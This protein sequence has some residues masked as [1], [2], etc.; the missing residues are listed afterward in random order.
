MSEVHRV[1]KNRNYTV[2]SNYHLRD[3][4]LSL[5]AKGLL[6]LILSLPDNWKFSVRGLADINKEGVGCIGA[7][8]KELEAGGYL[9]RITHRKKGKIDGTEYIFYEKSQLDKILNENNSV[10]ENDKPQTKKAN[11]PE[12]HTENPDTVISDTENDAQLNTNKSNTEIQN[13]DLLNT[14]PINSTEPEE[15]SEPVKPQQPE[16]IGMDKILAYRQLIK[17]NIEYDIL[18][19]KLNGNIGMLNE[20]VDIITETVCTT[21]EYLTV[22]S[23]ER[24]AE[25][26]KSKLLK[27]NSEHIEY[28]IDCMRNNTTDV[29]DTRKYLLAALFNAPSTIDSYYTLKV[30]HDMYGGN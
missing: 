29:H 5:K 11:T 7:T 13:T 10:P 14:Y 21:R 16:R 19:Q 3:M 8:L 25:T 23:E 18:C 24:N 2:M 4:N 20:I 22:A 15:N 1:V 6:S 17:Q 9:Q 12:P 28:V 26:V 27:L 30:N